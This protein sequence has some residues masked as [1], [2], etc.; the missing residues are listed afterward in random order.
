[1]SLRFTPSAVSEAKRMKT[2][3]RRNRPA[4]PDAF[5]QELNTALDRIVQ[6]P[7]LGK[8]Y[9]QGD[10]GVPVRRVLL[11]KTSTV[12]GTRDRWPACRARSGPATLP[13]SEFRAD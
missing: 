3:W 1:M 11:P 13:V 12:A 10:L 8:L 5:D 2:W 9:E 7:E 4:A 6:A